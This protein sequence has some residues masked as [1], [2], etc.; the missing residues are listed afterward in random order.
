MK[1]LKMA[2]AIAALAIGGM[3]TNASAD[4][5]NFVEA[6]EGNS[7]ISVWNIDVTNLTGSDFDRIELTVDNSHPI[8]TTTSPFIIIVAL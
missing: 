3:A 1:T 8:D 4:I 2:F 6:E 7:W 5:L